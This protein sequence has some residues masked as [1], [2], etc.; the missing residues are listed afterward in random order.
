MQ[1]R[2]LKHIQLIIHLTVNVF[3]SF[4]PR[5]A[6]FGNPIWSYG[7]FLQ[8]RVVPLEEQKWEFWMVMFSLCSGGPA[9]NAGE[10]GAE[11]A[12][13]A[14]AGGDPWVL[15]GSGE[16]HTSQSPAAVRGQPG[17]PAGAELLQPGPATPAAWGTA[18][19]RGLRPG[20]D[21]CQ[22]AAEETP[23]L[24][25]YFT[26]TCISS[27]QFRNALCI[28]MTFPPDLSDCWFPTCI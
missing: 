13:E 23:G 11:R 10:A 14:E 4:L 21:H 6:V 9:V 22:Q 28:K 5:A 12:G 19:T 20:P 24:F 7:L 1:I 8:F 18:G 16:H 27:F 26:D 2:I 25:S 15:A 3:I 17:R